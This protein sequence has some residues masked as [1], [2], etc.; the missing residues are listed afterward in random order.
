VLA[1]L[2][3]GTKDMLE[4][5]KLA[6][7]ISTNVFDSELMDLIGAALKDLNM[8]DVDPDVTIPTS[9][10]SMIIRAVCCYCGFHYELLHGSLERSS[11]YKKA[12]DE[13]KSQLGMA[14]GYTV[15]E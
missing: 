11:A 8:A 13:I 12:Y 2:L 1:L 3:K 5:V 7:L 15:W 4:K 14:T 10:D 6:L 9:T